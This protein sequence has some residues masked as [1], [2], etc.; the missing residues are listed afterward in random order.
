[1][2]PALAERTAA[3]SL[4]LD[5]TLSRGANG[6]IVVDE[7]QDRAGGSFPDMS[8]ALRFVEAQCKAFGCLVH[9]RFDES[10]A[11]IRAACA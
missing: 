2:L 3:A 11:M 7:A 8:S 4:P 6:A 9:T 10:L 5:F 1:M